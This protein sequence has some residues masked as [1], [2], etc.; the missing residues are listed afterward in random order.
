MSET[1]RN[2]VG[3]PKE[4]ASLAE[5]SLIM[6]DLQ[7]TY[8]RGVMELEN[9]QPAIDQAA[10][11]LD[12]ARSAGI[13]IF[14]IMHDAGEG[15]PYDVK[16]EIGQ[17]VD[18]V[19][20]R[21][22]EPVIVKNFPNSFTRTDLNDRLAPGS[23]LVLAGFMTHMCVNS[24]ARGAFS[25]GHSPSV[26]AGTTATRSL[27]GVDGTTVSAAALQVASLAAIQDMFG[28]VVPAAKDIPA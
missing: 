13:P 5:S 28:V 9:V 26:V 27:P 17:I 25:L 2:L 10:E 6:I 16:G 24:T 11:L 15:S 19:A 7:N 12:R 1:L 22:G 18:R 14:H 20:P 8:T 3:L 23:N 21:D 4:P